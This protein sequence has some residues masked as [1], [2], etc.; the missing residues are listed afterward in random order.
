MQLG[1][2]SEAEIVSSAPMLLFGSPESWLLNEKWRQ[3]LSKMKDLVG[4]VVDEV[5]LIYK[6]GQ[7]EKG[8]SAFRECFARLG[9]LRS[10]VKAGTPVLALTASA[11]L[12]SRAR[13][14]RLLLMDS[15]TI[16]NESPNRQNIRIGLKHH[17]GGS[18]D[19]LDWVVKEEKMLGVGRDPEHR[20]ENMLIGMFH[21]KTLQSNKSR[22]L[23][24]FSGDG[25][26]RVV[27]ATTA[28]G[29]GLNFPNISHV[30][31]YGVPEDVE[32][33]LQEIGR[34]GRDGSQSHAVVYCVKQHTPVDEKVKSLLQAVTSSCLRK[35]LYKHFEQQPSHIVPGHLCCTYCHSKCQCQPEGCKEPIPEYELPSEAKIQ[36]RCRQVTD[37]DK[38]LLA[39]LLTEYKDTL[40]PNSSHLYTT[41]AACTGFSDDLIKDVLEHCPNIFDINYICTHLPVFSKEHATKI[42][43]IIHEVFED[44]DNCPT[45]LSPESV[46]PPDVNYTGYYD[47]MHS[48]ELS[49]LS[50]QESGMS[51]IQWSD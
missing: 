36:T 35:E 24:S 31:L 34:A 19:C 1:V 11:D 14:K 40:L 9:E 44:I 23:S 49:S 18:L 42:L 7:G 43:R 21:S 46:S 20:Q 50:S 8:R 39:T 26:C 10:L 22:V 16:V 12:E 32:A 41:K 15:A 2:N 38:S 47:E 27:V 45:I 29:L 33:L 37:E 13:V 3:L 51:P 4:I 5:H 25:N 28:L 48:E 17:S 6:W 30:I